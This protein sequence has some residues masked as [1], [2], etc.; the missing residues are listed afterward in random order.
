MFDTVRNNSKIMMG[1]LF[2]LIIPSFVLFGLEGYS[3]FSDNAAEVARVDGQKITR[4]EWDEAHKR[5]ADRIRA[6]LPNIDSQL[7]D[8][9]EARLATLERMVNERALLAAAQK[10]LLL[11]SD[12][13]LARELQQ[14]PVIAGLRGPDGKL[15]MERYRQL[16]ASQGLTPEGFEARVRQDI[17]SRQVLTPLQVSVLPLAKQTDAALQAW[18]QRREVQVQKFATKDFAAKVQVSDTDL[19]TYYKA[20][21]DA[22]RTVE[23]ADVEYLV[24]DLNSLMASVSL[25]EQDLKTYYEQNLQRLAG[26]EQR[27]ASHILINAAKDAPAAER[28][29]ARTQAQDLLAQVRKNPKSFADLARKNSQDP[30][31]AGN[32]GDLDFFARGA[33]VKPFEDAVFGMKEGDI[34]DVV[35]SDF[36]FHIILLT[37][38]KTPKAPSFET[39]RPQLEADLRKQQAQ[40]KFA[41]LAETFSNSVYEQADALKPVADKLKLSL[42]QA[43]GVTRT[44]AAAT[45]AELANPK[46]LKALFSE[47]AISKQ[48][49]TEAIEIASNT[50]VSARIVR[51]HPSVVRPLPEVRDEVR[52]QF[53][54]SKSMELARAEGEALLTAAKTG[55]ATPGLGQPL[56]VSRDQL[57]SLPQALVDA[58][59]R[60]DPAK[61]PAFVGVDL[62]TEG[63]ALVRV[64]KLVAREAQTPEQARQTQQ[65]FAQLRSQAELQAY[66]AV[67]KK[68]LKAEIIPSAAKSIS[69]KENP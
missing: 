40:R 37:A 42:R 55:S 68:E 17:S 33:M 32:G 11:T 69:N 62:G 19:E 36:G 31:S 52:K 29:K 50:L 48:R 3:R 16:A 47:D 51:H 41:E 25:P 18:L 8:S 67:L 64:N 15:D 28:D 66:L 53:V 13:R 34:S 45:P 61:L 4:Q 60:A 26:Q 21:A 20:N 57:Q 43:N 24:L 65:Q 14:D 9:Q 12:A 2:L 10:Q 39:M 54:R 1:L 46:V 44:P 59:L 56:V 58:A 6:Q 27:R 30:G 49:N 38:I 63:Y 35:E 7:L 23:S 22:F 5:E